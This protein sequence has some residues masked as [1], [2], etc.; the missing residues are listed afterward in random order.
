MESGPPEIAHRS[1][2]PRSSPHSSRSAREARVMRVGGWERRTS[3]DS[4]LAPCGR[5][6][7]GEHCSRYAQGFMEGGCETGEQAAKQVAEAR[8]KKVGLRRFTPRRLM[9]V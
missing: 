7:A 3:R 2:I 8:G 5:N 4:T 1:P 6:A 9:A